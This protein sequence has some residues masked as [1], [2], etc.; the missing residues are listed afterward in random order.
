MG[1]GRKIK[2]KDKTFKTFKKCSMG[3]GR[4][5]KKKLKLLKLLKPLQILKWEGGRKNKK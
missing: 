3:G 2:K 1:G 5:I 4:K